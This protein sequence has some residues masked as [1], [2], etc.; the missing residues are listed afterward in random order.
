MVVGRI[1]IAVLFILF[2]AVQINDPDP[3]LWIALYA[4]IAVMAA[5][6]HFNVKTKP[7]L[8]G[9]MLICFIWLATLFP[10]FI[11]WIKMGMPSI[12][13]QMKAEEIHIELV[14]EFLGLLLS[15]IALFL[16]YRF[17]KKTFSIKVE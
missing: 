14:R 5:L 10:D 15:I 4:Y 7:F 8:L 16:L 6:G 17:D 3:W 2:A 13:D 9:G 1:I 12:I 11:R